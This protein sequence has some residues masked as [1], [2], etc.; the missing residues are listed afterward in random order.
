[1]V[2]NIAKEG[3]TQRIGYEVDDWAKL[4]GLHSQ[5]TSPHRYEL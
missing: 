3:A 2:E 1:M 4:I 5:W